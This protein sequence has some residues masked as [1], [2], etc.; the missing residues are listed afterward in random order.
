MAWRGVRHAPVRADH[1]VKAAA[2][3]AGG[4]PGDIGVLAAL[5]WQHGLA[6]ER[7]ARRG[8]AAGGAGGAPGGSG[9]GAPVTG[10]P[11]VSGDVMLP[12][13]VPSERKP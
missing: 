9:T 8:G 4:A 7:G 2:R 12:P 5:L 13:A 11:A 6:A 1:L 3:G 10:A